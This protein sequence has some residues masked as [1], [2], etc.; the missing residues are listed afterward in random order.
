MWPLPNPVRQRLAT[1]LDARLEPGLASVKR[2]LALVVVAPLLLAA[3]TAQSQDLAKPG[4]HAYRCANGQ[5]SDAPCPGGR[6]L[7]VA[8]PRSAEQQRQSR[9]AAQRDAAMAQQMAAERQAREHAAARHPA[10]M[11]GIGPQAQPPAAAASAPARRKKAR[12][13]EDLAHDGH[14][15][16]KH[17]TKKGDTWGGKVAGKHKSAAPGRQAQEGR[18]GQL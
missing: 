11:A 1:A 4:S 9:D 7:N 12:H 8:D 16:N 6:A 5:Y 14:R 13:D 10:P 18:M 2:D 3:A 15:G 17:H